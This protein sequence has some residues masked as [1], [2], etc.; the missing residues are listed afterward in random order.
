[1]LNSLLL[2]MDNIT[3]EGWIEVARVAKDFQE[4]TDAVLRLVLR[5]SL[6]VYRKMRVVEVAKNLIEELEVLESLL[7]IK[8]NQRQV[9]HERGPVETIDDVLYFSRTQRWCFRKQLC[10]SRT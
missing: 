6:D 1:M 10:G 3:L 7:V 2:S 8:L 5:F 9:A 4:A